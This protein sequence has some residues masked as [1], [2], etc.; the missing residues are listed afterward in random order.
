MTP[1]RFR[2]LAAVAL[3]VLVA[4]VVSKRLAVAYLQPPLTPHP[5]LGDA[6]RF[7]LAHNR[8]G[9]MGLPVGPYSRWL[10]SGVSIVVLVVLVRLLR[11]TGPGQRLR[12]ASLALI[13]G[14]AIGNLLDRLA[15]SRGVVDFID[16]GTAGWRFWTFNVADMAIDVGAAL[17]AWALLRA[18]A[19]AR[20]GPAK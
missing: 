16:V 18:P 1:R 8:Q 13:M 7:T 17:L 19:A 9:V 15:S 20:E 12:A 3:P 6:V 10:L 5:V 14:G 11:A 2:V 4:D